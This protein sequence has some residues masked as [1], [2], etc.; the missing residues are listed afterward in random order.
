M[1][2]QNSSIMGGTKPF[3]RTKELM[4]AFKGYHSEKMPDLYT[5]DQINA[6]AAPLQARIAEFEAKVEDRDA[7]ILAMTLEL[8][9]LRQQLESARAGVPDGWQL[10]PKQPTDEMM[11][12]GFD[13]RGSHMYGAA[14]RAMLAAALQPDGQ[15]ATGERGAAD[16][17]L[18]DD[19][20]LRFACRV[21]D[22]GSSPPEA[23]KHIAREG[24]MAIRTRLRAVATPR[25][26]QPEPAGEVTV[27]TDRSGAVVLVSRQDDEGRILSVI[28]EADGPYSAQEHK[29]EPAAQE[30]NVDLLAVCT[31]YRELQQAERADDA[32]ELQCTAKRILL[33][34]AIQRAEAITKGA[35]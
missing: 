32:S 33:E 25:A 26:E 20:A 34:G 5:A 23:D 3:N 16:V 13:V 35:A 18:S 1:A 6:A 10:V 27:T 15:A 22:S 8:H 19:D 4:W 11:Q 14:Y 17:R 28:W 2:E 12:A 31:R 7:A 29:P 21:L 9:K 24:L 30:V